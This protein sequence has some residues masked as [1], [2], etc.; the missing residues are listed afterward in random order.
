MYKKRVFQLGIILIFLILLLFTFKH[1]NNDNN[2][3][4][5]Y[6]HTASALIF[7]DKYEENN[8]YFVLAYD[9]NAHERTKKKMSIESKEVH[10]SI[11]LNKKYICTY[12]EN[13][14]GDILIDEVK[15]PNS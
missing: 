14:N 6:K 4:E 7:T 2:K 15:Q 12:T 8:K 1:L 3:K 5:L 9:P 13:P 10:D 11:I